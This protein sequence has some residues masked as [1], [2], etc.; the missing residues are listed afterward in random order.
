MD[1]LVADELLRYS[2]MDLKLSVASCISDIIGITA[3]YQPYNHSIPKEITTRTVSLPKTG[4][5]TSCQSF[6]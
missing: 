5:Q 3:P 6:F 1:A 4:N 2:E